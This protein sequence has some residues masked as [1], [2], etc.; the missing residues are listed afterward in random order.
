ML[1]SCV[2]RH[3][4]CLLLSRHLQKTGFEVTEKSLQLRSKLP[5]PFICSQSQ[6]ALT[7]KL[8]CIWYL[9]SPIHSLI[10]FVHASLNRWVLLNTIHLNPDADR[11][12]LAYTNFLLTGS[13]GSPPVSLKCSTLP[14]VK[15]HSVDQVSD[16][17]L[18][19][20]PN[21]FFR[22]LHFKAEHVIRVSISRFFANV[23]VS[24][25]ESAGLLLFMVQCSA[26]WRWALS[27]DHC[28]CI[29]F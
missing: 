9:L 13:L 11:A 4:R 12:L 26:P 2:C 20:F 19:C 3:S 29:K 15:W 27:F 18:S 21:C 8:H 1:F 17:L 6:V 23:A 28:A 5:R 14:C 16:S 10:C 25:L 7:H 24:L 22:I